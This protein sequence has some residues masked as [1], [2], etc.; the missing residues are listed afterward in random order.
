[1]PNIGLQNWFPFGLGFLYEKG[2]DLP[3]NIT[4]AMEP[5]QKEAARES[6]LVLIAILY[7]L[8]ACG[9]LL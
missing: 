7:L 6:G 4:K 1:M 5:Y 2:I 9:R 8:F 3:R